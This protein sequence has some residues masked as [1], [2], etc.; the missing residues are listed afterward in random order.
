MTY[1]I[2]V[3]LTTSRLDFMFISN[4]LQEFAPT[5]EILTA[6]SI[7]HSTVLFFLSKVTGCLRAKIIWK[8]NSSLTKD[9][10]YIT[11]IKK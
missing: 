7:D 4:T 11:K 6:I 5:A 3:D 9:Q 8:F 2:Y 10:N 1:E